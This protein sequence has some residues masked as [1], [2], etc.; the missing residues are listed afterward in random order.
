MGYRKFEAIVV[1][2]LER[3]VGAVV[4]VMATQGKGGRN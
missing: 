2:V 4:D 3:P 1:V